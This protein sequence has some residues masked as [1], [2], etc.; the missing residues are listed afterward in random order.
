MPY[1]QVRDGR[2]EW[3]TVLEDMGMPAGKPKSIVV[4]LSGRFAGPARQVRIVTSACVYW[5]EIFLSEDTGRPRT[6]MTAMSP[7]AADLNYR[8]FSPVLVH[9]ERRQPEEFVYGAAL[10]ASAWTP[11]PG[12]YTRF[13]DVKP[14]LGA[15]DDQFVIMGS[16][17]ELSLRFDAGAAPP[18]QPGWRRDFLLYADGWAKDSDANT[19]YSRTVE[20]LPFH[21][22]SR[23]P[24]PAGEQYPTGAA[25]RAYQAEYNT[26]PALRLLS[27]LRPGGTEVR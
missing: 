12:M 13:G 17:D 25:H 15:V 7:A 23:Y 16:G 26:R 19:A 20:P 18:L 8:G 11:T 24:Y 22:M 6:V 10:E 5:D 9:P 4:D 1:L 3:K 27:R 2:G 14:L 21:G